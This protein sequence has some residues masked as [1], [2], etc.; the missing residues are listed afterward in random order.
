MDWFTRPLPEPFV[1]ILSCGMWYLTLLLK[2]HLA[3]HTG[4]IITRFI[5]AQIGIQLPDGI[6]IADREAAEADR[7]AE[8]GFFGFGCLNCPALRYMRNRDR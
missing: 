5:Y 4:M 1:T 7:D 8:P 2:V 6:L 3:V